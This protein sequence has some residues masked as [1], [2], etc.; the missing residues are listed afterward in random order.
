MLWLPTAFVILFSLCYIGGLHSPVP[1]DVPIG[2]VGTTPQS[3][4]L[5]DGLQASSQGAMTGRAYRSVDT[6]AVRDGTVA[7][8][9]IPGAPGKPAEAVIA[10]AASGKQLA[11]FAEQALAPLAAAEKTTLHVRDVAP[12][13]V[14][15]I[16]GTVPF[17]TSL[18]ATIGGYLVGMF[19]G[20]LGGPLSRRVRW[21]VIIVSS[22]LLSL[23]L[24][25]VVG[26][27]LSAVSG[28]FLQV[29]LVSW[30]TM[31]ATGL[32]TDALGYYFARFTV[33]PALFLFVF[34][35][36][37]ACGGP[38]PV[39]FVPS[40]FRWLHHVVIGSYSIP[41]LQHSLYGAG[42]PVSDGIYG[43]AGYAAAGV[44]LAWAG[45]YY[46]AWRRRRREKL[47]LSPAGMMGEAS[48]Q[49]MML[50]SKAAAN[51]SSAAMAR[52]PRTWA[53]EEL[54]SGV[55]SEMEAEI[56]TTRELRRDE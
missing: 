28:H 37:P 18:V 4:E 8:L 53:L 14:R 23:A 2:V 27:V 30:A 51:D 36:V 56:E 40:L 5:A 55:L 34:I 13:P 42:S 44:A 52:P 26:P 29:W 47:G 49:L 10:S 33:I 31:L 11:S 3:R 35:N 17:F 38:Y 41:L 22:V 46:A 24:T 9:F 1:H 39:Y 32:V 12:L 6:A 45:P 43:L 21:A 19:C 15:D 25:I 48:H 20:M 54:S 16:A 50:A 7:A